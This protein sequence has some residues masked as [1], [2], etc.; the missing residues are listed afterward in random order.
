MHSENEQKPYIVKRGKL[1]ASE[2][3]VRNEMNVDETS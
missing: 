2:D 1:H 3:N